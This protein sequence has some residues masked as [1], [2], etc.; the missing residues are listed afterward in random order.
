MPTA[1]NDRSIYRDDVSNLHAYV[2]VDP[3]R[4]MHL[5]GLEQ[6]TVLAIERFR[7]TSRM[8]S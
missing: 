4:N 6:Y 5:P 1:E 3:P 2:A 7:Q 8:M